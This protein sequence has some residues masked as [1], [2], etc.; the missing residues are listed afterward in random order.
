[1]V[2][3]QVCG[4]LVAI[5]LQC[6][7]ATAQQ[8]VSLVRIS[9][10]QT[11]AVVDL[12]VLRQQTVEIPSPTPLSD[13][14]RSEVFQLDLFS[15][16]SFRAVRQRFEP[17]L[18]GTSWV[19]TL[20]GYPE[21]RAL[22]VEVAGE[23]IGHLYAPFGFF[24]IAPD[25]GNAY[26]VQ[27]LAPAVERESDAVIPPRA[28]PDSGPSTVREAAADDGSVIDVLVA[29]TRDALNGFG[30]ETRARAA[31]DLA[32][33]ETTEAL[34]GTGINSRIRLVRAVMVDYSE[35]GDSGAD[36]DRLRVRSDGHLDSLHTLRDQHAADLVALITERVESSVCGRG[37][38][39]SPNRYSGEDAYALSVTNRRCLGNGRT[40]AHELGHNMGAHHDW[41]ATADAG[42]YSYAKGHVSLQGRFLDI[43]SYRDL[44][45]DS[46]VDCSQ[47][48]AYSAPNRSHGGY[49]QGV[50]A[51]TSTACTARNRSNP[52]CD[53]D[54]ARAFANTLPLVAAYRGSQSN[55]AP[56][57]T[58]SC[59]PCTVTT[60]QTSTLRA[61]A[62]DPDGDSLT[63]RWTAASGTF[64]ASTAS[65]TTWTA[66]NDAANV[67]ATITVQDGRGGSASATVSIQVARTDRLQPGTRL[68][69]G[70]SLWSTNNRY[71]L[72]YQTDGNLVLY[73]ETARTALWA[74]GTGGTT[75][76]Q[77]A[78]QTDG[79]FV[80]YDADG[81]VRFSTGTAGN[82]NAYLLVQNDGNVVIYSASGPPIWD[83]HR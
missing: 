39:T 73:D 50:S 4:L 34:R 29:Y 38:I 31:I 22:F 83:R 45:T 18:Y 24:R 61:A 20:D 25:R 77:A 68:L 69:V 46:G 48:L 15:D 26:L 59:S 49:R 27:Q 16:V 55:R 37:Y 21:S 2:R 8:V 44:C 10:S 36:L 14:Q 56:T 64:S 75:T 62:T 71:R 80:I 6:Q 9:T 19:G 1:M 79:H 78:M 30:G 74:T 12:D 60:G 66:P 57:V 5:V 35:T 51:G 81:A 41:Y 76:G 43:M 52:P 72:L 33:A 58:A 63:Y 54:L 67:T 23:V 32:V 7:L 82:T 65:S 40:F 17:T 53:A 70:E 11:P 3:W 42:A 13:P 28:E 47:L